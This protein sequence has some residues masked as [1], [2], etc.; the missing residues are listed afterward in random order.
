VAP[1]GL[2]GGEPGEIGHNIVRRVSGQTEELGG[3]DQTAVR[4][5]DTITIVTPTGGGFGRRLP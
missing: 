3:A 4:A 5:G 2:N 1:F